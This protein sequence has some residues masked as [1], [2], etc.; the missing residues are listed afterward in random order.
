MQSSVPALV[1]T[2]LVFIQGPVSAHTAGAEAGDT[3]EVPPVPAGHRQIVVGT[4]GATITEDGQSR[5]IVV[6]GHKGEAEQAAEA[7]RARR[8]ELHN[9]RINERANYGPRDY[10]IFDDFN[11]RREWERYNQ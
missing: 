10:E 2:A 3:A 9:R 11:A 6:G 7:E 1:L 5:R 8:H 4:R